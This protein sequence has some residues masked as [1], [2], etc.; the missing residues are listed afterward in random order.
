MHKTRFIHASSIL[1]P[2]THTGTGTTS[3]AIT[4]LSLLACCALTE[5]T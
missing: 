2:H 5:A 1:F 4:L 3:T